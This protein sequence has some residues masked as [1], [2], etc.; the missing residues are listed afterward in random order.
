MQFSTEI[1]LKHGLVHHKCLSTHL[2][3]HFKNISNTTEVI[4]KLHLKT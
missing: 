3:V 2:A 4:M 1:T